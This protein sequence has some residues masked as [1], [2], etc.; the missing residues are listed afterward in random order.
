MGPALLSALFVLS[1]LG[2]LGCADDATSAELLNEESVEGIYEDG[3]PIPRED[4]KGDALAAQI[5]AYAPLPAD[6]SAAQLRS[7]AQVL[8]APEDPVATIEQELVRQVIAA[9]AADT[10]Q[11]DE[12]SNPY[13]IRYAVYN[14]RN[15]ELVELLA[16]AHEQGVDVQII[17]EADQLKP[18][19]DYNTADEQ[20]VE[21]GFELVGRHQA[22][23]DQTRQ[24]ADLIGV[25]SSGLMHLKTRIFSTPAQTL[26]LTGSLNPGD[27]AMLNEESLH[28]ISDPALIARYATAFEAVRD[29][30]KLANVWDDQ[31]AMNVLFTPAG[32]GPR[33]VTKVFDWLKD[34][35]EQILLMVFSLRDISAPGHDESLVELLGQKVAQG[36]PVYVITDRKQSDGIDAQGNKIMWNDGTEDALRRVGVKVYEAT[37][38]ATPFTAMH[39]KVA[40][41]GRKRIRVIS[42]AAN[43][44]KAGLGTSTRKATNVESQLFIDS[45]AL[46]NNLT[47][48]RYLGQFMRVLSRYAEQTPAEPSFD[49]V[50]GALTTRPDWPTVP[51]SFKAHELY[52]Q[53]GE[54][55]RIL[56]DHAVLGA[57]GQVHDG[58]RLTT[59]GRSYPT[60]FM[61][62]DAQIPVGTMMRYK[63]VIHRA[64]TPLRWEKGDDRQGFAQ[65][66]LW[67]D[68][69]HARFEGQWR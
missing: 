9:R 49:Q 68:D 20:L 30:K 29:G 50:Y 22:L 41:L 59:D 63:F 2:A 61:A 55:G 46:D 19:K 14:L 4:G 37:N 64:N 35:Q 13:S 62:Q 25:A 40:I 11:Y 42:D 44:T 51:L 1:Q 45:A 6:W 28:L 36:V 8:F 60:W 26:M 5:P 15:P 54:S 65:P 53:W 57:W 34:E 31:A 56:G 43:W 3:P 39:H 58:L 24:S 66:T 27:N 23:T 12:G 7:P 16:Q 52:T 18:E 38:R 69:G 67:A 48:R 47:G 33:A 17:I 21:R 32:S 10:A